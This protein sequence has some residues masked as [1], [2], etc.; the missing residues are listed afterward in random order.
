[1]CSA[2]VGDGAKRKRCPRLV[3]W[4]SMLI[5]A[6]VSTAGGLPNTIERGVERDCDA[7]QIF[8]QSPRMWRPTAYSDEDFAAFREAIDD[9]PIS[10]VLIHA[11]YLINAATKEQE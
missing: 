2:P 8:H 3:C 7:I 10:S 5:G 4:L 11:V 6:H 1:M 9:S